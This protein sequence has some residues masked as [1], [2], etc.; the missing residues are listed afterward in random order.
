MQH[1][2]A[3]GSAPGA[4]R[5]G[6]TL[7]GLLPAQP[8]SRSASLLYDTGTYSLTTLL[9]GFFSHHILLLLTER[10]TRGKKVCLAFLSIK[11]T[12]LPKADWVSIIIRLLCATLLS[13]WAT[14]STTDSPCPWIITKILTNIWIWVF[15]SRCNFAFNNW[16][17]NGFLAN[18]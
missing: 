9:W 10:N 4:A 11:G 5:L 6:H 7:P 8:R 13:F 14:I 12:Q 16:K 18:K 15:L 3:A 17:Q 2:G 1:T